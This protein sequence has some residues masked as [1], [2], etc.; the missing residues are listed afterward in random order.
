MQQP[1]KGLALLSLAGGALAFHVVAK[2]SP[3]DAT[4]SRCSHDVPKALSISAWRR[5]RQQGHAQ[6]GGGAR[7]VLDLLQIGAAGDAA[8]EPD[9]AQARKFPLH[10]D[11]V[12]PMRFRYA[13]FLLNKVGGGCIYFARSALLVLQ[14]CLQNE[15]VRLHWLS[16]VGG[17]WPCPVLQ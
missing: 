14:T 9:H 1:A 12:E 2:T 13:L 4:M 11:G 15:P 17:S 16:M 7:R 5:R 10:L 8:E 6:S 3:R